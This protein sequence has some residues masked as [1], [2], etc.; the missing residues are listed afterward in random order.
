MKFDTIIIGGGQAGLA[1]GYALSKRKESYII[2]D[3]NEDVG[4][5]WRDRYDSLTLFTPRKYNQLFNI[6]LNGNPNTFPTKDEIALYL[7]DFQ[8]NHELPIILNQKVI[9]L[10][11]EN[12]EWYRVIT[13]SHSYLAKN[14]VIAT[15]A[16]HTPFIPRIHDSSIEQMMHISEYRNPEQIANNKVLI[17]GAGNSG[18]QVAAE[19]T[20]SHQ[21]Y[22]SKS[23]M[24]KRLPPEIAGKSLFWWMEIFGVMKADTNSF[25]GKI[26][27]KNDP[28]IGEDLKTVKNAVRIM[29]RL[30]KIKDGFAH[31]H[32]GDKFTVDTVIWATGYR[33]DYSWVE[34]EGV[35]DQ[36]G[37]PIH[38]SGVSNER[39]IYFIGLSWQR[40]RGSALLKGISNDAHVIAD[41]M[42]QKK[43][44]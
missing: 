24:L 42:T 26:L 20:K 2:I 32:N 36:E 6:S 35:I 41:V 3:E 37:I 14:V 39:G 23:K 28:L 18:I 5:S 34:V 40:N 15:G 10:K 43:K 25:V 33:N 22:L 11:R 4:T 31:F 30:E 19:L 17:V 27:K 8:Q 9:K 13:Q 7:K 16:F 12:K 38:K 44:V 1:M 29:N 21:V